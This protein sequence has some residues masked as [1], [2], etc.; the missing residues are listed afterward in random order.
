MAPFSSFFFLFLSIAT[1]Q[2]VMAQASQLEAP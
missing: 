1:Q 2:M